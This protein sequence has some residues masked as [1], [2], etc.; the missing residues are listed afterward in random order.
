M[1]A[2]LARRA[3]IGD[4]CTM[5]RRLVFL[6]GAGAGADGAPM[7]PAHL[8]DA[9]QADE[10]GRWR[11]EL[12]RLGDPEAPEPEAWQ[13]DI[14]RALEGKAPDT[15]VLAHSLGASTF[16]QYAAR[17]KAPPRLAALVTLA[18]P[19]WGVEGWQGDFAPPPGYAAG[20]AGVGR[21]V[22]C[23]CRDDDVVPEDHLIRYVNDLAE[24][25]TREL[26]AGGHDFEPPALDAVL[27]V[28]RRLN[29]S[30]G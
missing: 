23:H 12:P 2:T 14:A 26:P 1:H 16:L 27:A 8:L 30:A 15:V 29:R 13:A 11:V 7:G 21:I 5:R 24:A 6:H 25:E 4:I 17:A 3:R 9:L 28:L 10:G 19:Y 22:L 20:L 18:A